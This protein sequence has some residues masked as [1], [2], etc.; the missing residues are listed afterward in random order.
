MFVPTV[1]ETHIQQV[2][3]ALAIILN[4]VQS[5]SE[6]QLDTM[7]E[8]LESERKKSVQITS[9]VALFM[10]FVREYSEFE[11]HFNFI[12][13][14]KTRG[15]HANALTN[16]PDI[17]LQ[18][19]SHVKSFV[20]H[21]E[22]IGVPHSLAV[23][24][25]ASGIGVTII[26]GATVY[27]LNMATLRE[28][29]CA[30]VD[31]STMI[32]YWKKDP[33]CSSRDKSALLLDMVAGAGDVLDESEEDAPDDVAE[34]HA[35][36][37]TS[38]LSFDEDDVPTFNDNILECLRSE[39]S[40]VL[41]DI[42]KQSIRREG[43]RHC[44]LCPFRSFTQLRLLRTH[45]VKHHTSRNQYVC[46][47]TKKIKIILA[48]HDHAASSQSGI[49]NLLQE[50]AG[51]LRQT[52]Q[53]PLQCSQNNIDKQISL[54]F[55][56]I[57]TSRVF[58]KKMESMNAVLLKQDEWH[59]IS[60]D[61]TLKLCMKLMGQASYRAPKDVRNE[62]PFGDDSA[63]QLVD[64]LT[65]HFSVDQLRAVV[66]IGTD[67][68][69]EKLFNQL[70]TVCPSMKSLILDPIHLAIVYEYG[71]WNKKSPGSKQLRRI[72]RKCI[73]IDVGLG[74]DYWGAFYDGTN[75]RPLGESEMKYRHMISNSSMNLDSIL[76][77][78]DIDAPFTDRLE[79]IKSIAALCRRYPAEVSRKID[80]ANKQISK[81]LW[82]ACAPDRLEW[83]MNN[84]VS[85]MLFNH[86]TD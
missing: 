45:I 28:I 47:G 84:C 14:V 35:V 53:P 16:V 68:P 82:S 17:L 66:H 57:I 1:L 11:K 75:A 77:G 63:E 26:D 24:V 21:Y 81:I 61:A 19:G 40:N 8:M 80:G 69:S 4:W 33:Q 6:K 56:D 71:F 86:L 13:L 31:H 74:Q 67:K 50:S 73:S 54:V 48:L 32:S 20:L 5:M 37:G 55:D 25:D 3:N 79:F 7:F 36:D 58:S 65:E 10:P 70:K 23:R 76:D 41:N 60:M 30:A 83:L 15:T 64:A 42:Q 9:V 22:G 51:I 46:S 78:L 43:R 44:P 49:A 18:P 34:V 52:V 29:H 72:L 39:T 2:K 85:G 27:K 38:R 59:Y 62:A 12:D